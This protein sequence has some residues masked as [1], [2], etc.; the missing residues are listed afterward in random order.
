MSWLSSLVREIVGNDTYYN[1]IRPVWRHPKKIFKKVKV[2]VKA[3]S[4][5]NDGFQVRPMNPF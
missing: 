2:G 1:H 4:N 3:S 5:G